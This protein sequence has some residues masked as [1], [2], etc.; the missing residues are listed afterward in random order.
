MRKILFLVLI[1]VIIAGCGGDKDPA[2][3][4]GTWNY[5]TSDGKIEI[6]FD[7]VSD[8][9]GLSIAKAVMKVDGTAYNT[10]KVVTGFSGSTIAD[11]RF[12]TND[13]KAVYAYSIE[14]IN[15]TISSDNRSISAATLKY[16]WPYN[17]IH[18]MSQQTINRQ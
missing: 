2:S 5:K 9:N 12:N 7:I 16:T 15:C 13:S 6:T 8:A 4:A 14:F 18:E 17:S 11:M 1:V 10:E 3:P